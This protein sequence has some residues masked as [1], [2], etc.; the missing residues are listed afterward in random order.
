MKNI[1]NKRRYC[2]ELGNKLNTV[3]TN[4]YLNRKEIK[5][6]RQKLSDKLMLIGIDIS[7]QS[8][9]DIEIGK[10]TVLD[11]ELCAFAKVLNTSAD[12]LLKDF[13]ASLDKV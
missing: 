13:K 3:G 12:E 11:Y 9:Y 1:T 7:T 4:I 5:Y 2:K 6:S 10:R 8:I